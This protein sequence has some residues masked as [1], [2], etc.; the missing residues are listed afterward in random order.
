MLEMYVSTC[1]CHL[2]ASVAC[3]NVLLR[4]MVHVMVSVDVSRADV[5]GM[6]EEMVAERMLALCARHSDG[7]VVGSVLC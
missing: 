6:S 2:G 3:G 4:S 5:V 1:L 7:V